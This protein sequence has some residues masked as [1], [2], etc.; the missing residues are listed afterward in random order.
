MRFMIAFELFVWF[1]TFSFQSQLRNSFEKSN[2]LNKIWLKW[3]N[4]HIF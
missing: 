3:L 1:D 2:K 4:S